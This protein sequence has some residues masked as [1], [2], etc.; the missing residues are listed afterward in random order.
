MASFEV[1]RDGR[2]LRWV[3]VGVTGESHGHALVRRRP[4]RRT[5]V[6]VRDAAPEAFG[7]LLAAVARD[8]EGPLYAVI[9][10]ADTGQLAA[11]TSSGFVPARRESEY[12][13]DVATA[14]GRLG[15]A[16]LPAGYTLVGVEEVTVDEL[17]RDGTR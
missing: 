3:A 12:G 11:V 17:V 5:F 1:R 4:D 14:H 16:R 7:P 8:V 13:I 2:E 9:D 6:F 15:D 10:A